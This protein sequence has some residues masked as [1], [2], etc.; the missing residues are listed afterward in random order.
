MMLNFCARYEAS[1]QE[2]RTNADVAERFGSAASTARVPRGPPKR[3]GNEKVGALHVV[4]I[5][6]CNV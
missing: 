1:I 4:V 3:V 2:G 5:T 6:L